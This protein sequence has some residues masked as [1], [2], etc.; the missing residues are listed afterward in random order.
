MRGILLV[1]HGRFAEAF[2]EA[3]EM[4][5]GEANNVYC[6]CLD[7]QDGPES[8]TK[9]I[10]DIE[11]N[12]DQ[13]DEVIVFSDL[14]GGTPCNISMFKYLENDKFTLVSGMNFP[15]VLTAILTPN[16]DPNNLVQLGKEGIMNIKE[17]LK[18]EL[19]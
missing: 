7:V 6:V 10:E 13:Y 18:N 5:S 11:D 9:K 14:F 4:I 8:F 1:S 12:F 3:L 19:S 16:E 17:S 2:K 15:M